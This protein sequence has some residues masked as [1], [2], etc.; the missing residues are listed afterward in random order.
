MHK[1]LKRIL[2]I[3][4]ILTMI[5][6]SN[7]I[8][9]SAS[10][11]ILYGDVD[12]S[13][14]I[15]VRDALK[16]LY[17]VAEKGSLTE[18]ELKLSDVDVDG[19]VDAEDAYLIF[20]CACDL[21]TGFRIDEFKAN[22]TLWIAG[23]SIA[24]GGRSYIG[25][26]QVIGDYLN[27]DA[28]VNNTALSGRTA[29]SFTT[30]ANYERIMEEMRP[31]DIW[32]IAFGHNDVRG[33]LNYSSPY[34][35]SETVGSYKYYLKYYYIEPAYRRGVQPILMSSVAR[36]NGMLGSETEQF[37]Y[38]F[39]K[40]AR[41]LAEEYKSNGV[42]LPFIDMFGLTFDEYVYLGKNAALRKY[43]SGGDTVHYNETGAKFAA[44][45]ILRTI[46]QN[47]WDF[48]KYIADEI[49]DPRECVKPK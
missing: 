18:E 36:C 12:K 44:Q 29:K 2:S 38:L 10:E 49:A 35:S 41:E 15:T 25:W 8:N 19:D 24:E 14:R 48:A 34:F 9:V 43:H 13:D 26:G 7:L 4:L 42:D 39:I 1:I 31:G 16:V 45:L 21:H 5:F 22:G 37:H 23:D 40:A 30:E 20:L 27:E 32:I 3:L 46:Q 47:G 17:Y 11:Y 6:S 33:S 28:T